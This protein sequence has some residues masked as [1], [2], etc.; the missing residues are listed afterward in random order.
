M[1]GPIALVLLLALPFAG[2]VAAMLLP[3]NARTAAASLA[4]AVALAA[5]VTALACYGAVTAGG[6]LRF[7]V[8]WLPVGGV[9]FALRM[10]G[11]AWMFCMIVTAIGF[12]VAVYARYYMSPGDP[13]PRFY[14]FLL[15]FM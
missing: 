11:Y 13:V 4:G 6:V 5:L 2:S 12:L 1:P 7:T 9:D 10:D 8:P 14:S 15:A 3:A